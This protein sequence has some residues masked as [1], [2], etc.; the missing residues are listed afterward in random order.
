MCYQFQ[1]LVAHIVDSYTAQVMKIQASAFGFFCFSFRGFEVLFPGCS[2][3]EAQGWP[4]PFFHIEIRPTAHLISLFSC[5]C[6]L[7]Q[8]FFSALSDLSPTTPCP[9]SSSEPGDDDHSAAKLA[10]RTEGEAATVRS[11]CERKKQALLYSLPL[12]LPLPDCVH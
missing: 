11:Q 2:Y 6:C 12:W 4:N 8:H 1:C 10:T 7:A 9:A 5:M 3:K